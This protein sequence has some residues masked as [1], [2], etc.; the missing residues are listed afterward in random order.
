MLNGLNLLDLK[1]KTLIGITLQYVANT[2]IGFG[3]NSTC[4]LARV[5]KPMYAKKS[6]IKTP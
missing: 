6:N 5:F 2:V 1:H 3:D 4:I